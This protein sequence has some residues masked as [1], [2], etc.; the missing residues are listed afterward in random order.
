MALLNYSTTISVEKTCNE[1]QKILITGKASKISF[2]YE[3]G[4]PINITFSCYFK[5]TLATFSLPCRFD[6]ITKII[7]EDKRID[8]R[9]RNPQQAQKVAW[10]ILKDWIEAQLAI[11]AAE[12][13]ELP[14]VFMQYGVTRSGERLY[15]YIKNLEQN[16][17]PLM[18]GQ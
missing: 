14:E 11:V 18:L 16:N 15:D 2:D 10:R 4:I 5:G 17:S 12:M 6:G 7:V 8:R 9:Y 1:I 3:N 13:A